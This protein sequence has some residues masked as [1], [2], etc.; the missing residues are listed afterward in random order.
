MRKLFLLYTIFCLT[1]CFKEL[2]FNLNFEGEKIV[3]KG[4]ISPQDGAIIQLNHTLNPEGTYYHDSV[5]IYIDNAIVQLYENDVLLKTL[6]YS[7]EEGFYRDNSIDLK[8]EAEYHLTV[9]AVGYPSVKTHKIRIPDV[10]EITFDLKEQDEYSTKVYISLL[11]N[12]STTH[13]QILVNGI[14]LGNLVDLR[15]NLIGIIEQW[16]ACGFIESS[17]SDYYINDN[18][19][20]NTGIVFPLDIQTDQ[21]RSLVNFS[22]MLYLESPEK[23]IIRFRSITKPIYDFVATTDAPEDIDHAFIE[24]TIIVS[25][26]EGGYGYFSAYQEIS[27]TLNP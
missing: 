16:E 2:D 10:P 9:E 6:P 23:I 11:D 7:G 14:Y 5:D 12:S 20:Q 1:G 4:T 3:I 13:Y 21:V 18:C 17:L 27:Y 15:F 8:L 22:Q 25:N 24:P 26:V 19:F